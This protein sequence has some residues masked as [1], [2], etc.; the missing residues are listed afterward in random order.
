MFSFLV[1]AQV[2]VKFMLSSVFVYYSMKEKPIAICMFVH[3]SLSVM[4]GS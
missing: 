1:V 2:N 4:K 3:I